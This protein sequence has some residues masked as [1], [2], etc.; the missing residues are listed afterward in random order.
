M[1][2][3]EIMQQ[4]LEA[5]EATIDVPCYGG[6]P[7]QETAAAAL[8]ERLAQPEQEPATKAGELRAMKDEF[9]KQPEQE[10]VVWIDEIIEDI[11]SLYDSEMIKELAEQAHCYACEYAQRP[12]YNPHNPYNQLIYKKRYDSKFAELIVRKCIQVCNSRVGN[13]DYNTGRTH[14]ASDEDRALQAIQ[15]SSNQRGTHETN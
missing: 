6:H 4:A 12:D 9:W 1:T 5:L 2:D 3:R 8:R 14:C 13:I 10:P 11:H 7:K 15:A